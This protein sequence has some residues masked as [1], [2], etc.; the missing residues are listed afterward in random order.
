[1]AGILHGLALASRLTFV[2]VLPALVLLARRVRNLRYAA[3]FLA[4]SVLVAAPF[5]LVVKREAGLVWFPDLG[6]SPVSL[7]AFAKAWINHAVFEALGPDTVVVLGL[8]TLSSRRTLL[9]GLSTEVGQY[10]M[11]AAAPTVAL[12]ALFPWE[13]AY[14]VPAFPFLLIYLG[15][16]LPRRL[17][18]VLLLVWVVNGYVSVPAK[19][20]PSDHARAQVHAIGLGDWFR[21]MELRNHKVHLL[22]D[23]QRAAPERGVVVLLE[24]AMPVLWFHVREDILETHRIVVVGDRIWNFN[25]PLYD[26][27]TD[28]YYAPSWVRKVPAWKLPAE[29]QR[30][31][32]DLRS[33][34]RLVRQ[35]PPTAP[36]GNP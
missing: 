13:A 9:G 25:N 18:V 11:L 19:T 1:M 36:V 33:G 21:L 15:R 7:G 20:R 3:L 5:Y 23:I 30:F 17:L 8:V 10:T 12:F 32:F 27:L 2:G 24:D 34:P 26:R 16:Y 31:Q 28:D 6:G 22:G 35:E 4:I 14:L 29:R